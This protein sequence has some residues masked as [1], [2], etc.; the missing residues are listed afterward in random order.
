MLALG[1]AKLAIL[2]KEL[3]PGA[4]PRTPYHFMVQFAVRP[5][6]S[7]QTNPLSWWNPAIFPE[8][9]SS[10]CQLL[11]LTDVFVRQFAG[12]IEQS[13]PR[14]PRHAT[15]EAAETRV[16]SVEIL[17]REL[18]FFGTFFG[19]IFDTNFGRFFRLLPRFLHVCQSRTA[20]FSICVFAPKCKPRFCIKPIVNIYVSSS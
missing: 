12:S 17:G 10:T 5:H 13:A 4:R 7:H 9:G 20:G 1:K 19:T 16:K 11:V 3:F 15:A 18:K 2:S 8:D 14:R 6:P